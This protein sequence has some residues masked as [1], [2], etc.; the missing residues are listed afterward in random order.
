MPA[1]SSLKQEIPEGFRDFVKLS[2]EQAHRAFEMLAAIRA[3]E[4]ARA[5][6]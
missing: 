3:K 2:I 5:S 1:E 6:R 4:P